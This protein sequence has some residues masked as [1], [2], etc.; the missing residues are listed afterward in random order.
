MLG[1]KLKA[2]VIYRGLEGWDL[3]MR[4]IKHIRWGE[5]SCRYAK[6]GNTVFIFF[7]N[8]EDG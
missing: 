3:L 7:R 2:Y 4:K 8:A 5:I 1:I 6:V